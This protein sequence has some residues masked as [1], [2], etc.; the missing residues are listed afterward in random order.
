MATGFIAAGAGITRGGTAAKPQMVDIAPFLAE[1]LG[2][3][4]PEAEGI[5]NRAPCRLHCE[6]WQE[7]GPCPSATAEPCVVL[8]N[9]KER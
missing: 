3:R 7:D 8:K 1:L 4:L 6:P 2:L 5:P 9:K